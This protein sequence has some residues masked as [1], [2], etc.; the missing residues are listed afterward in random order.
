[1]SRSGAIEMHKNYSNA[2]NTLESE[3]NMFHMHTVNANRIVI[4]GKISE[5][6]QQLNSK[7]VAMTNTETLQDIEDAKNLV[8]MKLNMIL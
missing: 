6:E 3:S 1:M 5:L 7:L 4:L 8:K 2:L